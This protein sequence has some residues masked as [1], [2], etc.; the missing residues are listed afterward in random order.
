MICQKIEFKVSQ[1][2][3]ER[4]AIQDQL[5]HQERIFARIEIRR[6]GRILLECEYKNR[7]GC[8]GAYRC[9]NCQTNYT[10]NN[11]QFPEVAT[12]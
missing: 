5:L 3:A 10:V 6:Q 11:Q 4:N 8:L 9:D 1:L 12:P 2:K 7:L